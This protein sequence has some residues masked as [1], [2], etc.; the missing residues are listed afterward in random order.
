VDIKDEI[1][2]IASSHKWLT[3]AIVALIA[4]LLFMKFY[5]HDTTIPVDKEVRVRQ[6]SLDA[7]DR[8]RGIEDVHLQQI[9]TQDSIDIADLQDQLDNQQQVIDKINARYKVCL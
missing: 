8:R 4:V 1:S 3:F 2:T 9:H 7:R 6:D 5:G